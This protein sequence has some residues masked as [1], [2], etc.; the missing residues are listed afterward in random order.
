MKNMK[1]LVQTSKTPAVKI[2]VLGEGNKAFSY[3]AGSSV[4]ESL[5]QRFGLL[6]D[7]TIM[8]EELVQCT[9]KLST[10]WNKDLKRKETVKDGS[11][12]PVYEEQAPY[13]KVTG[14]LT[15]RDEDGRPISTREQIGTQAIVGGQSE[16][17]SSF[18]SAATD[19]MKKCASMYGIHLD[20]YKKDEKVGTNETSF[21]ASDIESLKSIK[22]KLGLDSNEG[23]NLYVAEYFSDFNMDWTV[24]SP[25]NIKDFIQWIEEKYLVVAPEEAAAPKQRKE[26]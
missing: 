23:L 20:I 16:Q 17:L 21:K 7:F 8:K 5:N 13:A 2:K 10:F 9:P 19:A 6:W 15:I 24:L 12:Q 22:E 26:K 14:R 3:V 25:L 18:K 1:R 11:G 4:I